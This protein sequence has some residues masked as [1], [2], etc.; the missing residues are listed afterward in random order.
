MMFKTLNDLSTKERH[1]ALLRCC[2]SQSWVKKMN[3]NHPF[4]SNED[5]HQKA[6]D[7]WKQMETDDILEAFRGHPMIGANLD[8]LRKK[9]QTTSTWS[10]GEQAG[11]QQAS[12]DI[13]RE[14]QK[15]NQ[16]YVQKFGYIFIVCAT[17]KT[18][19]QMLNLIKERFHNTAEKELGIAAG[20][21]QK[22]TAIRL[23][24]L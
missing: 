22:I 15:A 20:E 16:D 8:E 11:M 17:G 1:Q 24:K 23:E 19:E 3:S 2:H 7:V 18:A 9:F 6:I 10:E 13:I 21:Q 14:L 4:S 12:E 5:V